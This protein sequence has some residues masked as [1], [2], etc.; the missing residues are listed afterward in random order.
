MLA[1][2]LVLAAASA[3]HAQDADLVLNHSDSPD[4][5]PANGVFTY[6]LRI[7][8]NGPGAATNVRLADT[9]PPGSIFLSAVPT[10]GSC[11]T[12]PVNQ[13]A[14]PGGGSIGCNLGNLPA[15][16]PSSSVSVV[17]RLRLP[18]A[19]VYTN[20][21]TA[22]S[23]TNDQ[24]LANN[25]WDQ[26]T[27][28]VEAAD[29]GLVVTPSATTVVAGAPYSYSVVSSNLGPDPLAAAATQQIRFTVPVGSIVTQRP[30]G[31]GW[32][33]VPADSDDYP[34]PSGEDIVCSL[35]GPLP[36]GASAPPLVVNAV[37]TVAGNIAAAFTV[38]AS[39]ADGTPMPDGDPSNNTRAVDIESDA[40]SDVALRKTATPTAVELGQNV[41]F[42][43]T[44]Q[45]RGGVPPGGSGLIT[46]TD[47][48]P[49]GL[50]A[51]S[52]AGTGWACSIL[53]QTITCTRPG[54]YLGGNFTDMPPIS[55]VATA[56][57]L[58]SLNN[59]AV[60]SIPETDP[61]PA[62]DT[63][64]ASVTASNDADLVMSKVATLSPVVPGQDFAFTL[65]VRNGGPLAV[66]AGQ[67]ITVS[68]TLPAGLALAGTPSG[69]GWSC[70]VVGQLVE[71][72]RPG[73]LAVNASAPAITVPVRATVATPLV[74]QACV[75]LSGA[76]PADSAAGN[77]C[78][79]APVT[80][81]TST[82]DLRI[83]KLA[84]GPVQAGQDLTYTLTVTND[85]PD[86]A[87]NVTVADTL[88]S[89]VAS[90]GGLQNVTTS[91]G[92]CTLPALPA[93]VSSFALECNLGT[94]AL[95]ETA[96]V[97]ITVRPSIAATGTRTNTATV[98][99]PD[100]G[101]PN[102]TNNT[103]TASSQ[104][105]EILNLRAGKTATPAEVPAGTPVT[106]V[107]S[108][109]NEG[110]S[111]ARQA[112]ITDTLP[113]NAVLIGRPVASNSGSCTVPPAGTP[114]GTLQ[115]T[116][117]SVP[118]G[119]QRTVTYRMRPLGSAQG[120]S[121]VNS[122]TVSTATLETQFSD[123]TATRTVAVLPADLDI[124]INKSDSA[125]PISLG[126]LTTYTI[127]MTNAGPSYG[128]NLVMTDVFPAPGSTPTATF[129]YQGNLTVS[130]GGT[131]AQ[132][133]AVGA[134]AGTLSCSFPGIE[135]GASAVVTYRMRAEALLIPGAT[136]G[137]GFNRATTAVDETERTLANNSITE[138][139]T[140]N[141][142]AIPTDLAIA[143]T[144]GSAVAV[145][146]GNLVYTLTV[147]NNGPDPSDGAQ[148]IDTLPAGTSFVSGTGCVDTGSAVQCAVGPL[149]VGQSK[150]FSVTL[151]L[152]QPYTGARPL[153][154]TASVDAPG[155]TNPGNNQAQVSTPVG[156]YDT[157]PIPT[158]SQW[159]L[160]LLSLLVAGVAWRQQ[161]R[162]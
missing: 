46:V 62:N 110:P 3:A 84:S 66:R 155:D 92:S 82:A 80:S 140:T 95:N 39:K 159:A 109:T 25:S 12:P 153:V 123:N 53:G 31:P 2:P 37:S 19:A 154:N 6:T 38:S 47:T 68:D 104:V 115:C 74:N 136:S 77:N 27:T 54:P 22:S 146:G 51:V 101:D 144:A 142:N 134:T 63:A 127:T 120:Q 141:R 156:A 41:T 56:N 139:T 50:S 61:V 114:G 124:V 28:V 30:S 10:A 79:D 130:N 129:S 33:C 24:N 83:A 65:G 1:L 87:T 94:L 21:A 160:I 57:S 102:Q 86:A 35:P 59:S 48:L 15:T 112:R 81:T 26:P 14:P 58:G 11:T 122:V 157:T 126:Q 34:L 116:W 42:T 71:C 36:S 128:S 55:V 137:T 135:N 73:P 89:L 16:T 7:D 143:K 106:F 32:S 103:A 113:A 45:H 111:V 151:R 23:D 5:G 96:T 107:A 75:A 18:L 133:P 13:V 97:Q 64:T 69:N 121:L 88:N 99:S 9:T 4:P 162:R 72:S 17:V 117:A 132:Q 152:A 49:A 60:V 148:V 43:L 76:G 150:A 67:T 40:G 105:T 118:S 98:R 108:L 131:C 20:R 161:A 8:N 91:H 70:S 85:G 90:A 138:Q 125:D 29:L 78:A 119:A 145:P 158:L 93:N 44:A 100:V 149:A 52:A 147:T